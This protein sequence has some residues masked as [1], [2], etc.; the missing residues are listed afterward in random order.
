MSSVVLTQ[1]EFSSFVFDQSSLD[2]N[3]ANQ[4]LLELYGQHPQH[5]D[6]SLNIDH[7]ESSDLLIEQEQTINTTEFKRPTPTTNENNVEHHHNYSS[8]KVKALEE[9]LKGYFGA[10]Y[11]PIENGETTNKMAIKDIVKSICEDVEE[12]SFHILDLS[13]VVRQVERWRN[14]LPRLNP[15]YAV[16]CNPNENIVKIMYMLGCGF[17]CASLNEIKT[18]TQ[19]CTDVDEWLVKN[20]EYYRALAIANNVSIG[21]CMKKKF[22]PST[23]IIFANPTKQ[24]THIRHARDNNVEWTTIDSPQEVEKLARQW[25]NA[26]GVIRIKTDDSHSAC[27]FSSK[28]GVSLA[29]VHEIFQAAKQNGIQLVGVSF[30]VGSGCMDIQSYVKAIKDARTVFNMAEEEYGFKFNLL[31]IG[32]GFLGNVHETPSVEDVADNIRDLIDDLFPSHVKVIAEPGRY[33]A[34]AAS[35]L[36]CNIF[37]K[38]DLRKENEQYYQQVAQS[39]GEEN[40]VRDKDDFIYYV[41][42]GIYGSYNNVYFDHAEPAFNTIRMFTSEKDDNVKTYKS[43]IFGPTCD[44]IDVLAKGY[45]LPELE[46]G[47]F[48]FTPNF[49]AYTTASSSQ[50][51]GFKATSFTYIWRN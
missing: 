13:H 14:A 44:S 50:F 24:L 20:P 1:S 46:E 10:E 11:F 23:D 21:T 17:D 32:G 31:D 41:N 6:S 25:K 15:Y 4:F 8:R 22:N 38:K 12:E 7:V 39:S 51:N 9:I 48:F 27:A 45:L 33:I 16:K 47:D 36:V 2:Y 35:T 30:H 34:Q 29:K 40:V 42:D 43:T 5:I 3:Q 49:G 18:V 19:I 37:S 28:F 26:K